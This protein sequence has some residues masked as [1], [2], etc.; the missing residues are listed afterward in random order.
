MSKLPLFPLNTVL[1]P[2]ATIPLHVFEDRYKAMINQCV[3][4]NSSF[5]VV[6][7]RLGLEEG[8]SA[9]PYDI[10]TTAKIT[11]IDD[12]GEGRL[13]INAM[14]GEKFRIIKLIEDKAFLEANVEFLADKEDQDICRNIVI[15]LNQ[16]LNNNV[17]LVAGLRGEFFSN[18]NIPC[19]LIELSYYV[20]SC[21]LGIGNIELQNLLE[22][23]STKKRLEKGID[24]LKK[25]RYLLKELV[26]NKF[27]SDTSSKN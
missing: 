16:L 5:G 18:V 7:I 13:F 19:D 25:N 10:G 14:G 20:P 11:K 9:I 26:S 4:T 27:N 2:K 23:L 22:E 8:D 21:L 1:F 12:L 17:R 24:L 15:E 3:N 6:L